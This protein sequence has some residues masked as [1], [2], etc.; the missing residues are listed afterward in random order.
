MLRCF[1]GGEAMP[2]GCHVSVAESDDVECAIGGHCMR[3]LLLSHYL[4]SWKACMRRVRHVDMGGSDA[5]CTTQVKCP[6][7]AASEQT[8]IAMT[9][10]VILECELLLPT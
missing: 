1:E 5:H 6:A 4:S 2:V 10:G 3:G 8:Q 9:T 7:T